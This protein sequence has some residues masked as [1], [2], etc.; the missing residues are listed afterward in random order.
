MWRCPCDKGV[1]CLYGTLKLGTLLAVAVETA[2]GRLCRIEII[3][4]LLTGIKQ[5][6]L[7][8]EQGYLLLVLG[9]TQV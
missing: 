9:N 6:L 4:H 2:L 5:C 3:V 1:R 8:A 7:I